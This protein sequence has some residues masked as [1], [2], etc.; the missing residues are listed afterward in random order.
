MAG[1]LSKWGIAQI[2]AICAGYASYPFDTV[3]APVVPLF[4]A[5]YMR[6]TAAMM[7][8]HCTGIQNKLELH[9]AQTAQHTALNVSAAVHRVKHNEQHL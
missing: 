1:L 4:H 7:L 8:L 2:V 9:L 5:Y 3:S 6:S